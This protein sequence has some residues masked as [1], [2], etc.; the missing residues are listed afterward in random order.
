FVS[1]FVKKDYTANLEEYE[2]AGGPTDPVSLLVA[3]G[4]AKSRGD[5]TR[6]I[7]Q[8]G[9]RVNG[10]KQDQRRMLQPGDI[11]SARRRNIQLK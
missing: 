11:I 5:A 9:F 3:T 2:L 10:E 6:L 4:I 7:E 8:G 1:Q